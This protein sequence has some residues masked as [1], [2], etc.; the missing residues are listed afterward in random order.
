MLQVAYELLHRQLAPVLTGVQCMLA[1]KRAGTHE[2]GLGLQNSW[3]VE[4]MATGCFQSVSDSAIHL[5][6]PHA[7]GRLHIIAC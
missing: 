2:A 5:R 3:N 4:T 6:V 1:L 7:F